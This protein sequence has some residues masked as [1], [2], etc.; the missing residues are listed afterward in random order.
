ML[1]VVAWMSINQEL[2]PLYVS[3]KRLSTICITSVRAHCSGRLR[4]KR[5]GGGERKWLVGI[6]IQDNIRYIF[7][8]FTFILRSIFIA[9]NVW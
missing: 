2:Q 6:L 1:D 9:V 3:Y 7:S 8:F 4:W 5:L